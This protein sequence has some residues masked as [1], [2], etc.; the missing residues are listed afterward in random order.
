MT[1]LNPWGSRQ[2]LSPS[3]PGIHSS[4]SPSNPF[5]QA[6]HSPGISHLLCLQ[7]LRTSP[8]P[9]LG[10]KR[11]EGGVSPQKR[12]VKIRKEQRLPEFTVL[13]HSW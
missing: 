10:W 4:S 7:L 8:L 3:L 11:H 6:H 2:V 5:S 12:E 1:L 9:S 13:T